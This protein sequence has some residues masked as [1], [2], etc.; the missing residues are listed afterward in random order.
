M[1][2]TIILILVLTLILSVQFVTAGE[3]QVKHKNGIVLAMF[4]KGK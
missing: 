1:K 4:V 3:H 2:R